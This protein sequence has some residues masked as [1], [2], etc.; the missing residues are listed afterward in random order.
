MALSAQQNVWRIVKLQNKIPKPDLK[1][2]KQCYAY[3]LKTN[4]SHSDIKNVGPQLSETKTNKS[5]HSLIS[6]ITS[7]TD[8]LISHKSKGRVHKDKQIQKSFMETQSNQN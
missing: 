8:S 5:K 4:I 2:D 7:Y 3:K 1:F 6:D